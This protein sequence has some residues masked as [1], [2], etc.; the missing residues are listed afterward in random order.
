MDGEKDPRCLLVCLGVAERLLSTAPPLRLGDV[1][2]RV[3]GPVKRCAATTRHPDTGV[4]NLQTL[5]MIGAY[6]GRQQSA[7]GLGFNFGV[8]A[9]V[10]TPGSIRVGD[11]ITVGD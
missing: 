6:R 3:G 9:D 2:A 10:V 4:I 7:F 11:V 1:V 8:Y 5:R